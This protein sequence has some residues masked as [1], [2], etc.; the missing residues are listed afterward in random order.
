MSGIFSSDSR[1]SAIRYEC[2]VCKAHIFNEALTCSVC[3]ELRSLD[4]QPIVPINP[5]V[6]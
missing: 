5:K 2:E 1:K 3:G 6:K 4:S